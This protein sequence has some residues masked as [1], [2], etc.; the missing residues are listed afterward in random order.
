VPGALSLDVKWQGRE[1][2]TPPSSDGVKNNGVMFLHGIALN[3]F[4]EE[5]A[6]AFFSFGATVPI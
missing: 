6:L 5:L 2:G 4:I 3:Y 1:A